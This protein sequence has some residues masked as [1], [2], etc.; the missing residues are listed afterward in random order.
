LSTKITIEY[1]E[2]CFLDDLSVI[3]RRTESDVTNL[4]KPVVALAVALCALNYTRNEKVHEVNFKGNAVFTGLASPLARN[5]TKVEIL[6][7]YLYLTFS[8]NPNTGPIKPASPKDRHLSG[9]K[10][11]L[12]SGP[13][14]YIIGIFL[15]TFSSQINQLSLTTCQ[16]TTEILLIYECGFFSGNILSL[17]T[18]YSIEHLQS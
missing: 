7:K 15:N 18:V 14:S 1:E 5:D 10:G 9:P 2:N 6:V 11:R 8:Y 17:I 4:G 13:I 3:A 16:D 12:A